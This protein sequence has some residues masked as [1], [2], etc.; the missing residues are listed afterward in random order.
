MIGINN[1][2]SKH[3]FCAIALFAG[4]LATCHPAAR[5]AP[6]AAPST[7]SSTS[8]I[9]A[10]QQKLIAASKQLASLDKQASALDARAS[11]LA[12]M[13]QYAQAQ[14]FCG[15][16]AVIYHREA[17]L[18]RQQAQSLT[19]AGDAA[20]A[21]EKY[22]QALAADRHFLRSM[23]TEVALIKKES[24]AE[25]RTPKPIKL[26]PPVPPVRSARPPV[27]AASPRPATLP[28]NS[29]EM[30]SPV[31]SA[32]RMPL[33]VLA[34]KPAKPA[35]KLHSASRS[36]LLLL[37]PLRRLAAQSFRHAAQFAAAAQS[38]GNHHAAQARAAQ[39]RAAQARAAQA[40]AAQA[41]AAQARA[42]QARAAQAR[43]AQARAAQT[44][45]VPTLLPMHKLATPVANKTSAARQAH[46]PVPVRIAT[47][48][49]PRLTPPF[50]NLALLTEV[51]WTGVQEIIVDQTFEQGAPVLRKISGPWIF[52]ADNTWEREVGTE[53]GVLFPA[54]G[55]FTLTDSQLTLLTRQEGGR[56]QTTVFRYAISRP[57]GILSLLATTPNG[58]ERYILYAQGTENRI[59]RP[60]DLDTLGPSP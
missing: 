5:A 8:N 28:P 3:F 39:A 24:V 4:L 48:P 27:V 47:L 20:S 52:H 59:R 18:A 60:S 14:L 7:M 58:Y 36:N 9:A 42:A 53:N 32:L 25:A 2:T 30:P 51:G 35:I 46:R 16:A 43:A 26:R 22:A 29:K 40:R 1:F 54:H 15:Q 23:A 33:P 19:K 57:L 13:H 34:V 45:S 12:K 55:I 50:R 49:A 31:K 17:R 10:H 11:L 41:R 21:A 44:L 56:T 38:L 6:I 37:T